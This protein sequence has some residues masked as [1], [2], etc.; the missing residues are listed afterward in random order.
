M[1]LLFQRCELSNS[2]DLV[3]GGNQML[4]TTILENFLL[5]AASIH[6]L[7]PLPFFASSKAGRR[8]GD[9]LCCLRSPLDLPARS[10]AATTEQQR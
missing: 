8:L 9:F 4:I 2:A 5:Y 1:F 7:Q 6:T 3:E 10:G